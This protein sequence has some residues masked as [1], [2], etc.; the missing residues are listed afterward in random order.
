MN[1]HI[2][3]LDCTLRD[4]GYY[5]NWDFD[6]EVV[7]DYLNA[8]ANANIDYVEL[9]LRNFAQ[10]GFH[11]AFAYTTEDYLNQIELPQGPVYGVMVDAKTILESDLG[12]NKAVDELFI[13][14]EMSKIGLVRVAA[15]F[16]EVIASERIV[17]RLR[18]KGYLVGFNMMQAG[19]KPDALISEMS[20]VVNGWD[21]VDTLYFADSLGNMDSDEVKRIVKAI[22]V[23]WEGDIGI[24]THNNMAKALDNTITAKNS[25]VNWLDVTITGMGRGA[26]NAQ[27][28]NLLAILA[29]TDDKYNPEMV[30]ELVI[31]H[32]EPMQKES[33]WGSNLA[34]FLGAQYDI[35]PT[36]IQNLL[37]NPE[38]ESSEIVN[39]IKYLSDLEGTSSYSGEILNN[40]I[41]F[42]GTSEQVSGEKDLVGRFSSREVLVL[43]NGPSLE[44]YAKDI[45]RYINKNNPIVLAVN[46][47]TAIP[48]DLIDFYC[49]SHNAKFISQRTYYK[50]LNKPIIA[51]LHRFTTEEKSILSGSTNVLDY[52]FEVVANKFDVMDKYCQLPYEVTLAYALAIAKVADA[53]SISLVGVDGYNASDNR[54]L[55]MIEVLNSYKKSYELVEL[56][57]LTPTTYP[58]SQKSI[59]APK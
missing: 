10:T 35:H 14:A 53:D 42:S 50:N 33:G 55:E 32:F 7:I 16:H 12:I 19:G 5:N 1:K 41:S 40:A 31:K 56:N 6:T 58:I 57:A 44:K 38:H 4:G 13:D 34:Y 27:T 45:S 8:V 36:Y 9:G 29:K 18:E 28:E 43:A 49:I 52:G 25:G 48:E 39:A 15:H 30:Y 54:Q 11:G 37:S 21:C 17:K 24:H 51:P 47:V 59:F 3:V 22:K 20:F 2:K 23:S 46:I 26:G